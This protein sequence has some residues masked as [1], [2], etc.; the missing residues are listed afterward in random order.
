MNFEHMRIKPKA[1]LKDTRQQK[2]GNKNRISIY[3]E[4]MVSD[5]LKSVI[6]CSYYPVLCLI[7]KTGLL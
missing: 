6:P 3:L 4:Y 1:Q 7:Q 5:K 2:T